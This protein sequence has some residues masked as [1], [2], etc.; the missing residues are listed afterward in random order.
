MLVLS[1]FP[2][3][4]LLDYAFE[5]EGFTVVRGPDVIFHSLSDVRTFHPPAN[6][7]DGVIGGPPCQF[8]SKLANLVRAQGHEPRFGNLIPEFER[9]VSE[10]VP[11][12]FLMEN[13]PDAPE[14]VVPNYK[15]HSSLLNNRWLGEEQNRLRRFSF[16]SWTGAKL[17]IETLALESAMY[18][19]SAVIAD[20]VVPRSARQWKPPTVTSNVGGRSAAEGSRAR[21]RSFVPGAVT[22]AHAGEPKSGNPR[23][24]W[25]YKL[26]EALALQGLPPDFLDDAPF[27]AAGK[28][29]AIA[30]GVPIPMGRAVARA[31]KQAIYPD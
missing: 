6:K 20:S 15:V 2:G 24:Q 19:P 22:A 7:F 30:N 26:P 13:V 1:L 17:K 9:C 14:P 21:V 11:Y 27:T 16:G 4:G 18:A 25:R 5:L 29:S 12:W 8:A 31:V 10:A 28:L 3:I 23:R